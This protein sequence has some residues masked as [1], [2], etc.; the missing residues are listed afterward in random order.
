MPKPPAWMIRE[1]VMA[2]MVGALLYSA[3]SPP[4]LPSSFAGSHP[5]P[6]VTR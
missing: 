2:A 6:A 4:W 5:R 3:A 1:A